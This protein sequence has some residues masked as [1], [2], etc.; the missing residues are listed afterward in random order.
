MS[1][2]FVRETIEVCVLFGRLYEFVFCSGDSKFVSCSGDYMLL[3][4]VRETIEV[5]V[6]FGRSIH[7]DLRCKTLH[8]PFKKN[9]ADQWT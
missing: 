1:L 5:C 6:L 4:F 2:C 9:W 7:E 8:T 3:C